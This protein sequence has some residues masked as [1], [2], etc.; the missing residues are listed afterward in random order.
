MIGARFNPWALGVAIAVAM[1]TLTWFAGWWTVPLVALV[2]GAM[3]HEAGGRSI[4]LA[5]AAAEAWGALLLLDGAGPGF[6]A[7]SRA[8]GGVLTRPAPLVIAVTLLFAMGL[9]WS[10]ATVG[11]EVGRAL[12]R[13]R[14][15]RA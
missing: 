4:A 14:E 13:P 1:A 8:L 9:A 11:A 12:A 2:V 7:L 15:V 6:G 5:W 10:A 3:L